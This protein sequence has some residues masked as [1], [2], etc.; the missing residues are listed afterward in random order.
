MKNKTTK[1]LLII[2]LLLAM[3][4]GV[5]A[6]VAFGP[7]S[8]SAEA[9]L[10]V[11]ELPESTEA[12]IP[13]T[14]EEAPIV[15]NQLLP[16]QEAPTEETAEPAILNLKIWNRT[17]GPNRY[18]MEEIAAITF[19]DSLEGAGE[20]AWDV[21]EAG[22]GAILAWTAPSTYAEGLRDLYIGSNEEMYAGSNP[23]FSN[24][25]RL[26]AFHNA[27]LLNTSKTVSL[28]FAFSNTGIESNVPLELD[29]SGW[30]TS[31]VTD[32]SGMF[33]YSDI[34]G[35][36]LSGWDTSSVTDLSRMFWGCDELV[37]VELPGWDVSSAVNM[38]SMF[39]CCSS[40]VSVDLSGWN[41][42]SDTSVAS[43]FCFCYSLEDVNLNGWDVSSL[44]SLAGL[45]GD[46][47]SLTHV[48]LSG[49]NPSSATS[50][51][52][53]FSDCSSLTS[54]DLSGWDVSRV[55]DLFHLF[56]GCSSLTSVN[57]SGW[58]VSSVK[59][60]RGIFQN[61]RSLT[62][63]DLSGWDVSSGTQFTR[64][65]SGCSS[66]TSV[67]LSGWDPS[68]ATNCGD[69]F[70]GCKELKTLDIGNWKLPSDC[71]VDRMIYDCRSL[72]NAEELVS[73]LGVSQSP[74]QADFPQDKLTELTAAELKWAAETSGLDYDQ[75]VGVYAEGDISR[76]EPIL[77]NLDLDKDGKKDT[78]KKILGEPGHFTYEV[79]FGNGKVFP[80]GIS[81]EH[82]GGCCGFVFAFSDINGSGKEDIIAVQV[83]TY[84]GAGGTELRIAVFL[85]ANGSYYRQNIQ[86]INLTMEDVGNGYVRL[87]CPNV[88]YREVIPFDESIHVLTNGE[89]PSGVGFQRYFGFDTVNGK[90]S[91][92]RIQ[93]VKLDGN[94]LIVLYSF[95]QACQMYLSENPTAAVWRLE[96]GGYFVIERMGTDVIR[97]YWLTE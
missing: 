11:A 34:T 61:C 78:I 58:N 85:D 42:A 90:T 82:T 53:M 45:F 67:N 18:P 26:Q 24:Y 3:G 55:E 6:W 47:T 73:A 80:L 43:M 89:T 41:I 92:F 51:S 49:W 29:L 54:V 57:L 20:D 4:T 70:F 94:K 30:D 22:N 38:K 86:N 79:H 16:T 60:F 64:M 32:M 15:E 84:L 21:S 25:Y 68:S 44:T 91:H 75:F 31:S 74:T 14:Q 23:D 19:V 17:L 72:T 35:V 36:N 27:S 1:I 81:P 83:H 48:D 2:A 96:P 69:M 9:G 39:G 28:K 97:D 13:T 50:L 10:S 59:D 5:L 93:D 62:T 63:L 65:F 76:P 66:L 37:R 7:A 52:S 77:E 88:G 12:E 8:A 40:L 46:C 71:A 56:Q 87:S 33:Q 95:A